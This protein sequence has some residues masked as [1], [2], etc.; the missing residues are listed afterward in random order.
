MFSL[1]DNFRWNILFFFRRKMGVTLDIKTMTEH[2]LRSVHTDRPIFSFRLRF[3]L[4]FYGFYVICRSCSYWSDSDSESDSDKIYI[5]SYTHFF[6]ISETNRRLKNR[7]GSVNRP[8]AHAIDEVLTNPIYKENAKITQTLLNDKLVQ[9]KDEFLYWVTYV[10][11]LKGAKHLLHS[12]AHDMSIIEF[13]SLD[14]Y[15]VLL[16]LSAAIF[17]SLIYFFLFCF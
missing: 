2:D 16:F 5:G 10:I 9:P 11:R 1:H 6:P 15:F 3:R 8:L 13:W 14:V 4:R 17:L 7:S 12:Y